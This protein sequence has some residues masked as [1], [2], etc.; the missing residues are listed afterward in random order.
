MMR[1]STIS[2]FISAAH[3]WLYDWPSEWESKW[4]LNPGAQQALLSDTS[5]KV[6]RLTAFEMQKSKDPIFFSTGGLDH[7]LSP[8]FLPLNRTAGEQWEFD[9]VSEDAKLAFVFGFYRDPNYSI[10]GAGNLRVS[11]EMVWANGTRFAQIDY[12]SEN[13]IEECEWGT[14]GIWRSDDFSYQFEV[15][16]D[17]QTARI[18]MKTPQL[19]GIIAMSSVARPRYPDGKTY[20]SENSTSEALP[21]FHFVDPIPAATTDVDLT[22]LGESFAWKGM[23]GMS[24]LWGAFSW[25]TC[26]QG[27]QFVRM[28]AGP[29]ALTMF[30]FT[31]NIKKGRVYPSIALFKYGVPVFATQRTE[32]SDTD[33]YF[34]FTKTYEGRVTGTLRDKVTGYELDLVSHSQKKHWTFIVEHESVAFEFILGGG[35][36][37]TGFIA[38]VQGGR[39]G[40]EQFLGTAL[41]EALTF[42]KKSPLF[43][44]QYSE[45]WHEL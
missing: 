39:V 42:P 10:L 36:G 38:S 37:G 18:G 31:S 1:A 5:C 30:T 7:F 12:P 29:Y 17:M 2:L 43:K 32:E 6:S 15:T 33:D 19:S 13:I 24:R 11:A 21:H 20:P 3:G 41:T 8:K 9:G 22:I 40:L 14:R 26:L 4:R 25:F 27:M 44:P 23:G 16:A 28:L 35:H 45:D 34:T